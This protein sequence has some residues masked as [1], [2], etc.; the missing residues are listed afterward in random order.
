MN[1]NIGSFAVQHSFRSKGS[2]DQILLLVGENNYL[3]SAV[4][5]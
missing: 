1:K 4:E 5:C 2:D 3:E